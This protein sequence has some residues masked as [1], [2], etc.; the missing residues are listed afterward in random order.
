M[1]IYVLLLV[2]GS[3][4]LCKAPGQ[5]P[6]IAKP[7]L[8][9]LKLASIIRNI[10]DHFESYTTNTTFTWF[11]CGNLGSKNRF[12]YYKRSDAL[13]SEEVCTYTDHSALRPQTIL[14][15][16]KE[17]TKISIS[18]LGEAQILNEEKIWR[19]FSK[20]W[21]STYDHS[22]YEKKTLLINWNELYPN[23]KLKF[24]FWAAVFRW[25]GELLKIWVSAFQFPM[26]NIPWMFHWQNNVSKQ[27][28]EIWGFIFARSNL[29]C[30]AWWMNWNEF[31]QI[32]LSDPSPI[33]VYP[34]H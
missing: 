5:A 2:T 20:H 25:Q 15:F 23:L 32:F 11:S 6:L 21:T 9:S 16:L 22:Q 13:K 26:A 3:L 19:F 10:E 18:Y 14:L 28:G 1:N 30:K 29:N 17:R 24:F 4:S 34:C 8:A 27:K 12:S 31:A 33:I 7:G